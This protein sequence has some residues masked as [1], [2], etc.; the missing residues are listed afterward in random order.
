[1]PLNQKMKTLRVTKEMRKRICVH[2][3]AHAVIAALAGESVR[4]LS[5]VPEDSPLDKKWKI[6]GRKGNLVSDLWGL[7]ES[8][9]N[10]LPFGF[11]RWI[12][13]KS[14]YQA[15]SKGFRSRVR[16]IAQLMA[17]ERG[18]LAVKKFEAETRRRL[19]A[20]ICVLVAGPIADEI[21]RGEDEPIYLWDEDPSPGDDVSKAEALSRLLPFRN[22]FE[23]AVATTEKA[24]RDPELWE[25][26]IRL[27]D[28]LEKRGDLEEFD[29]FL[30]KPR[31][32][33]PRSPRQRATSTQ[34]R[35]VGRGGATHPPSTPRTTPTKRRTGALQAEDRWLRRQQPRI[36]PTHDQFLNNSFEPRS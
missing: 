33:W 22:E 15:D 6:K 25:M 11:L 29:G 30:P 3:A 8:S 35:F 14:T 1:M 21:F 26:V 10:F 17:S 2:E 31:P 16:Q 28:E 24:L 18:P 12:K 23:T 9:H 4:R 19:R 7:C 27:A 20:E 5:V 32:C 34:R 36:H 13:D